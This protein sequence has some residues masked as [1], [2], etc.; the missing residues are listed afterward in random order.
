MK[1][2]FKKTLLLLTMGLCAQMMQAQYIPATGAETLYDNLLPSSC[3]HNDVGT[4][5]R[6]GMTGFG[7]Y[8]F[9]SPYY[10]NF[11]NVTVNSCL[12]IA[13]GGNPGFYWESSAG[14]SGSSAL[15]QSAYDP[16]VVLISPGP[17]AL[18][19]DVNRIFA[20]AVYYLADSMSYNMSIAEF[21]TGTNTFAPMSG[22]IFIQNYPGPN[23]HINIDADHYG[24]FGVVMQMTGG[25]LSRTQTVLSTPTP[26]TND[27]FQPGL[28][29]P[30]IAYLNNTAMEANIIGLSTSRNQYRTFTRGYLAG[31][32]Y[33]LY[34]SPPIYAELYEP[35]IAAPS[36]GIA[37]EYAITIARKY[38]V[39]GGAN[40]DILFQINEGPVTV[41]NDGSMGGYPSAINFNNTNIY[42]CLTY[43]YFYSGG[44]LVEQ[45]SLGW[46]TE[47][48]P[49]VYPTP[50][51]PSTFIGLDLDPNVAV[52]PITSP[53]AYLD[54]SIANGQNNESVMALSGR[55]SDW[56]KSAAFTYDN[57]T[58]GFGEHLMWKQV[59]TPSTWKTAADQSNL[60]NAIADEVKLYPNP[61]K[62]QVSLAFS[63]SDVDFS[64]EVINQL[65]Q[66]VLAKRTGT[67][68]VTIDLQDL[69]SGLYFVAIQNTES[70]AISN[71]KFIKE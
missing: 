1:T 47:G 62:D 18:P 67:T 9:G 31:A 59:S 26:P 50:N 54:I 29:E 39:I 63:A 15:P 69:P 53:G 45:L 19:A 25:I 21:N 17:S 51:Q 14:T 8:G 23:P 42:P 34:G 56:A 5:T 38:P 6:S 24:H 11:L 35:R 2:L 58:P 13:A 64:Y 66:S 28:I 16:D 4:D 3:S 27:M 70:N 33:S 32:P 44:S 71:L 22:P 52:Y 37:N 46:F 49:G 43:D 65:G 12:G 10:A 30:D 20:I 57:A 41:A 68:K 40:F 48:V 7:G 55:F 60:T 36:V 61:A